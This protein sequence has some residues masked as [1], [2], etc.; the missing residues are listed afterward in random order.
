MALIIMRLTKEK[1]IDLWR[2][3]ADIFK[4]EDSRYILDR[5]A[6]IDNI[7]KFIT[8]CRYE[9]NGETVNINGTDIVISGGGKPSRDYFGCKNDELTAG[10]A[11]KGVEL[12][13][14][15]FPAVFKDYIL[16]IGCLLGGFEFKPEPQMRDEFRIISNSI[17]AQN[18]DASLT[19][20]G[21]VRHPSSHFADN[22]Y[23]FNVIKTV[24]D[25]SEDKFDPK[26]SKLVLRWPTK[27]YYSDDVQA[28][29]SQ[30]ETLEYRFPYKF[31]YM[32]THN[33]VLHPI[34][35]MAYRNLV[36]QED[37]LIAYSS[38]EHLN[39]SFKNF[40]TGWKEYSEDIM[41]MIPDEERGDDFWDE[42]SKLLSIIMIKG[43]NLICMKQLLESGNKALILFGP[44][45]TGKTYHAQE[46]V[47]KELGIKRNELESHKFNINND[48]ERGAWTLIQFHPNYTYEDFIGGISPCL[49]G[50]TLAYTLKEGVFKILCDT[51]AKPQNKDKKFL[52]VIDEINRTDLSSVFG[53]LMYALEYRGHSLN[54]PNFTQGFVIP[55]NVYIIGTMNSIDKSLVTFDLA[56][57]RRFAFY[58]IM[59]DLSALPAMLAN[60]N[61][62]ESCLGAFIERCRELN[63][64]I[65][66]PSSDLQLGVDYQIG[67][68]Y[69]GKIKDFLT[70]R[71]YK[72]SPQMISPFELEK[73]WLY[74]LQP[75]IEEY[76]GNRIDDPQTKK[77]LNNIMDSFCKALQ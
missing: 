14:E 76:L 62:E 17:T 34:S 29:Q 66:E 58:K 4:K 19:S 56:L 48:Y 49:T 52:I 9:D 36:K 25:I 63:K 30:K 6:K 27:A 33:D 10:T 24:K 71:N 43:Q 2:S 53:E 64:Q 54:I 57:R 21:Q 20:E 5:Y 12:Q 35:L 75:L 55:D 67:H 69:F 74:H 32:W 26:Q 73:L 72:D 11:F 28:E 70:E 31:F 46:L 18:D 61:I 59:P 68:A 38:D 45:G 15:R 7:F 77:C 22:N 1:L 60:Y 40:T 16:E 44:P 41:K 50:G 42:M 3:K 47:C 39:Q 51:A 23:F 13:A 8:E 37:K 65:A